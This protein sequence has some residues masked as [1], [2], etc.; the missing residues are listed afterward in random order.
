[1]EDYLSEREQVDRVR[2]WVRENAP[3]ALAGILI[4]VGALVGWQQWQGWQERQAQSASEKYEQTLQALGRD[5]RDAATKMATQLKTDYSNTPYGDMA[6]LALARFHVDAGRWAD[7]SKY[8]AD[9]MESSEDAELRLVARLRLARVQRAEGKLDAALATLD[10][11]GSEL[12]GYAAAY[13]MVR[14]D[15]LLDRGDR[16]GALAAYR[17]AMEVKDEGLVDRE[18]LQLKVDD[19]GAAPATAASAGPAPAAAGGAR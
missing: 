11:G 14:G 12:A 17:R 8:L 5:D 15:V 1:M 19:L 10:G 4:G 6:E 18:L 7:A 9:V 3:W 2:A 13:A 16:A